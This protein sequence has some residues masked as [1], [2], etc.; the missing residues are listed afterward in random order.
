MAEELRD[1]YVDL[2]A[3]LQVGALNGHAFMV[4]LCGSLVEAFPTDA[5][6]VDALLAACEADHGILEAIA[7]A[8]DAGSVIPASTDRDSHFRDSALQFFVDVSNAGLKRAASPSPPDIEVPMRLQVGGGG[9][10]REPCSP[11]EEFNPWGYKHDF[12]RRLA[13]DLAS[14]SGE[15][16][17]P[18]A[19]SAAGEASAA[20]SPGEPGATPVIAGAAGEASATSPSGEPGETPVV[21]AAASEAIAVAVEAA[22]DMCEGVLALETDLYVQVGSMHFTTAYQASGSGTLFVRAGW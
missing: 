10:T 4:E 19:A 17:A 11:T 8:A 3:K 14:S 13:S 21:A 9:Q 18:M 5:Q 12:E 2:W 22:S 1:L 15:P 6:R 16:D 20:S 7:F